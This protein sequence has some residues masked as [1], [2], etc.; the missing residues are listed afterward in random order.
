[1]NLGSTFPLSCFKGEAMSTQQAT[2]SK[3]HRGLL[4][5]GVAAILFG[6]L[7][8]GIEVLLL[9]NTRMPASTTQ[10]SNVLFMLVTTLLTV[11]VPTLAT[12]IGVGS[13]LRYNWDVRIAHHNKAEEPK[14]LPEH[15]GTS[16]VER[17][18]IFS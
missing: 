14:T 18:E 16:S 1:M 17:K 2:S 3:L 6:I 4:I 15:M 7:W 5:Y 11:G 13:V 10:P 9:I 8:V 12:V